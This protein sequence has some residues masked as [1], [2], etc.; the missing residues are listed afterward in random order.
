MS[1]EQ[2]YLS[3]SKG[4]YIIISCMVES[5]PRARVIWS[6]D[7]QRILPEWP[8]QDQYALIIDR[9]KHNLLLKTVTADSFGVYSCSAENSLGVAQVSTDVSGRELKRFLIQTYQDFCCKGM[10][11]GLLTNMNNC[12]LRISTF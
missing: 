6:K 12:L 3:S 4:S 9:N 11:V 5:S 1:I 7:G 8:D 10:D 2:V